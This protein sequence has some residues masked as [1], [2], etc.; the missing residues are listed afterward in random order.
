MW[1]PDGD[2]IR[3]VLFARD[4]GKLSVGCKPDGAGD[5]GANALCQIPFDCYCEC[6]RFFPPQV[7]QLA[8]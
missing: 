6:F 8:R 3:F 5:E 2:A 1:V 7:I 4:L